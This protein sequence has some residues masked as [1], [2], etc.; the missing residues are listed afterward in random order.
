M[1][2]ARNTNLHVASLSRFDFVRFLRTLF[3]I[4]VLVF[5]VLEIGVPAVQLFKFSVMPYRDLW[6]HIS[7]ADEFNRTQEF[8]RDPFYEHAPPFTNFGLIDL[9]NGTAARVLGCQTRS[10]CAVTFLLGEMIFLLVAFWIGWSVGGGSVAGG[11][12]VLACWTFSKIIFPYHLALILVYLLYVSMWGP[13]NASGKLTIRNWEE[14]GRWGAV[15]RGACVGLSFAIHP[16]AGTFAVLVIAISMAIVYCRHSGNGANGRNSLKIL[17][18]F[19]ITFIVAAPWILFQARL[20]PFLAVHNEHNL[21]PAV[22][23]WTNKARYIPLFYW[24]ALYAFLIGTVT[25]MRRS[26]EWRAYMCIGLALLTTLAPWTFNHIAGLTSIYFPPRLPLFFPYGVVA[27]MIPVAVAGM[28][29]SKRKF[30]LA[31]VPILGCTVLLLV[32]GYRRVRVETYRLFQS[33][34]GTPYDYLAP[35]LGGDWHG[36]C[37]LSDPVTSYFARGMI[38]CYVIA[39]PAGDASATAPHTVRLQ[40]ALDALRNGPVV[41]DKAGLAVDAVLL[42]K[43]RTY[44]PEY[45]SEYP[46]FKDFMA[47]DYRQVQTTWSLQGWHKKMETANCILLTRDR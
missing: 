46:G 4:G 14:T 38:G 15:W 17:L 37:V 6:W 21:I 39:V 8:G 25:T 12:S 31:A 5:A 20:H 16:F 42:D 35:E 1:N 28:W 22:E 23:T 34:G 10:V 3:L 27:A 19:L 13:S 11:L 44:L 33:E 30:F 2:S 29:A 9:M 41:L 45:F 7:A 47:L 26:Q 32:Y 43:K 18:L 24:V 40:I 36:R